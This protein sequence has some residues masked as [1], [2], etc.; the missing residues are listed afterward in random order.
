MVDDSGERLV[1]IEEGIKGL[2]R[3]FDTF[4]TT[5][6]GHV[7][8]MKKATDRIGAVEVDQAATKGAITGSKWAMG[9]VGTLTIVAVYLGLKPQ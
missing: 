5:F 1:R 8:D 2:G 6:D 3:S 9:I 4:R 7:V